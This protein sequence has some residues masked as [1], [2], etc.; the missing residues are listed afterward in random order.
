MHRPSALGLTLAAGLLLLL[1]PAAASAQP[2]TSPMSHAPP[3][4][5]GG[6]VFTMSNAVSGNVVWA[7][8]I[9]RGGALIPVGHFATQGKGS[10]ASLADAGAV[11]LT[12]DHRY[13]LVVNAGSNTVSIFRVH[14]ANSGKLV[15]TL[16]DQ[17]S[18]RGVGPA[19]VTVHGSVVYVLNEGNATTPGGIAGFWLADHGLLLPLP[20]ARQPLSTSGATAAAQVGFNPAGTVLVV[21]EENT[22]QIDTYRVNAQGIAQTPTFTTSNGTTPYGFSFDPRGALIVSDAASGALT[23]Y[24]VA[25]SGALTVVSGSVPDGQLAPCWVAVA[26][27]GKLAYTS[28]AHGSKISSYS[29]GKGGTLTLLAGVAATTGTA[30]T[31]MAVGG[32]HGQYLLVLDAGAAEIQEFRIGST[33]GLTLLYTVS[34]LPSASEGLAAF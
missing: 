19:S 31:D 3:V 13:L 6:L 34:A 28:D 17:V 9:G 32:S 1:V 30:D 24:A 5:S 12:S 2:S 11:T 15:L 25:S 8:H 33:G 23:S 26:H 29:V 7:F 10:G 27:G 14:S 22:N 18:S 16:T 4:G 20:H 21:T